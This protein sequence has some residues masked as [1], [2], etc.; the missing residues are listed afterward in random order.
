MKVMNN[1]NR[2]C[3]EPPPSPAAAAAAPPSSLLLVWGAVEPWAR[4]LS[5]AL[6]CLRRTGCTLE[7]PQE[8]V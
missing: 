2:G 1:A 8:E 3:S 6:T 4:P 5:S 7:K